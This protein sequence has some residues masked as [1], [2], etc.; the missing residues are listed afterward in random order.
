MDSLNGR[1]A[2]R[3]IKTLNV[4]VNV[5]VNVKRKRQKLKFK[6]KLKLKFKSCEYVV[7]C[8]NKKVK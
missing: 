1:G 2:T 8:R 6:L 4:N 5:N 7:I 3:S